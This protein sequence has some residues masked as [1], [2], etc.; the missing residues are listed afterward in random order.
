M[1]RLEWA[2]GPAQG[3]RHVLLSAVSSKV[4]QYK[5]QLKISP[6]GGW[7]QFKDAT[8]TLVWLN[9][10]FASTLQVNCPCDTYQLFAPYWLQVPTKSRMMHT[11]VN[12]NKATKTNFL[13]GQFSYD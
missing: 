11:C 5:N 13:T 4:Q 3:G 6:G 10:V 7:A 8:D 9:P 1:V 2:G 12:S